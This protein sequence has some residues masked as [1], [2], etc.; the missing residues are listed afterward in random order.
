MEVIKAVCCIK[1]VMLKKEKTNEITKN[2]PSF[3]L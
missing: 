2:H 3:N 1:S